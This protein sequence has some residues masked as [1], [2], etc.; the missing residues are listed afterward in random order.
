MIW[1]REDREKFRGRVGAMWFT[2]MWMG[3]SLSGLRDE[4]SGTMDVEANSKYHGSGTPVWEPD[5]DVGAAGASTS[6]SRVC[7]SPI[8]QIEG[9]PS[10]Q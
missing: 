7:V 4:G 3:A 6:M 5:A 2:V 8:L 1:K 10:L 9:E